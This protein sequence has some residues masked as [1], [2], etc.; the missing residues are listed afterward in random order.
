MRTKFFLAI[1][2]LIKPRTLPNISVMDKTTGLLTPI[3]DNPNPIPYKTNL[4]HN[5]NLVVRKQLAP[6]LGILSGMHYGTSELAHIFLKKISTSNEPL[7]KGI[8]RDLKIIPD[9]EYA[10][11]EKMY[12]LNLKKVGK[13]GKIPSA[14]YIRTQSRV[15]KLRARLKNTIKFKHHVKLYGKLLGC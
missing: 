11:V 12:K 1:P 14:H 8:R 5:H 3:L 7:F 10:K 6:V 2:L 13:K 15:E 4:S 9:H